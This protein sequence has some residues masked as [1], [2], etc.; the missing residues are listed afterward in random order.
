MGENRKEHAS[1]VLLEKTNKKQTN[2]NNTAEKSK[3]LVSQRRRKKKKTPL[4]EEQKIN[5]N[6]LCMYKYCNIYKDISQNVIS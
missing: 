1:C 5:F 4:I 3:T 6:L 2:I